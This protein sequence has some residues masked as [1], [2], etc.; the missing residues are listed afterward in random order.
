MRRQ[1]NAKSI[2]L[3]LRQLMDEMVLEPEQ[4][5]LAVKAM[6][7][8]LHA[9]KVSD[10]KRLTKAIDEFLGRVLRAGDRTNDNDD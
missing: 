4:R 2:E 8:L 7:E 1:R 5:T 10:V 6:R 9:S 3:R